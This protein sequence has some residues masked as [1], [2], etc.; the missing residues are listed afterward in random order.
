V[1]QRNRKRQQKPVNRGGAI[2]RHAWSY[3][4]KLL[5]IVISLGLCCGIVFSRRLWLSGRN[6]PLVPVFDRGPL[7]SP[8]DYLSLGL[9]VV[10]PILIT[11][12]PRPRYVIVGFLI[13]VAVLG[14]LD[15]M[16]W[17]PWLFQYVFLLGALAFA[18]GEEADDRRTQVTLNACVLIM[19]STYFWSGVQKLNASFLKETWPQVSARA[20][21]FFPAAASLIR[22]SGFI[23]PVVEIAIG[24]GLLTRRFRNGAVIVALGAHLLVLVLLISSGENT[25]VWPWN[26]AMACSVFLLF[27]RNREL[28]GRRVLAPK[29]A[30]QILILI[31]FGFLPALSLV[32][33]WDSYLS[34]AL[35][36]GNSYQG[37]VLID[38]A[39]FNN[40]PAALRP[41]VWQ[42]SDPWFLDLNRWS[43]GELNVPIYP[44]PRVFRQ[45]AAR[46]CGYS[47]EA[48]TRLE[49]RGQPDLFTA[50]R[51]TQYYDCDHL[52]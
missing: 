23:V 16:R 2:H 32:D 43:F 6:F 39:A 13:L 44:E 31:V 35:Y 49:I 29:H 48:G 3:R 27:W 40:L 41:Y 42:Q 11:F 30:F 34:S 18:A 22:T 7:P 4:L 20:I 28:K 33:V 45:V 8:I 14:A 50:A 26:V 24:I 15:Q 21:S 9:L 10:L 25:V 5:K 36:S 1:N 46:V 12:I 51:Q 19:A 52:R 47:G 37:V 38:H 17:Q